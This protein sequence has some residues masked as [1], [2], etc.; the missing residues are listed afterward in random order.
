ML[1]RSLEIISSSFRMAMQELW[2]NKLR[3]FLSLFGI[4]IGIFCII[5]VLATV[6]SL[7][8]NIQNEIKTLGSN[9]IYVDKW[10]YGGGPDYPWWKYVNRPVPRYDEVKPI[11]ERTPNARYVAFALQGRGNVEFSG[12]LLNGVNVYSVSEE[13]IKIQ[14]L[15]MGFGRFISDAEFNYGTNVAVIGNEIAEKLFNEPELAVNKMISIAGRKILVAGVIEKQG[16]QMIGGWGFDQSVILPFLFGRTIYN[17]EKTDPV[18]MVQGR[19]QITS[20]GLKDELMVTMRSLHKLSPKQDDNFA[21]NDINDIGSQVEEAFAGLNI[22]GAVIGGISLIVGLF[23]VANIM[24]V[25]VKERTSQ[26]GLKKALGAKRQIILTEFL[27]ESAFLCMLGGLIG[28]FLVYLL[29]QILS[30]ALDFPVFISV[31]NMVWTFLICVIVG[32][33]AGIVP[34]IQA[35]KMNPVVAIRS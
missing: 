8:Q 25:T 15:T 30:K 9:T 27:L 21:L 10:D 18:I 4:T 28:L 33:I 35:A 17:E 32:V 34:A 2:K 5:G 14:P 22:G 19:E 31:G 1:R 6:N 20:K 3:T 11:K 29:A 13:Y 7:Q 26:I 16:K 23:G 24:F 12:Y